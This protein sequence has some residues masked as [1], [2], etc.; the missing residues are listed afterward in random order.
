MG[1]YVLKQRTVTANGI[2]FHYLEMGEGPLAL[3]LH[4]FP[5]SAHAWRHLLPRLAAAGY[6]AVAPFMRGYAPTSVAASG[7]YHAMDLGADACALHQAL[8]GD[9]RAV[10]IGHDWGALTVYAAALI[11]P[12][13]WR[14]CVT[15]SVPPMQVYGGSGAMFAYPQIKR[16]FYFWFFQMKVAQSIVSAND[17]AFIDGLWADWSPGF[18]APEDLK[19]VK[20]CLAAPEN[21]EAAIGY[22]RSNIKPDEFGVVVDPIPPLTQPLL[23]L[24]GEQDGCIAIDERVLAAVPSAAGAGSEARFVKG[25]GHFM[26][27]AQP[28]LVN[29]QIIDFLQR[30]I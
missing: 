15:M 14:R 4:G 24:H 13:A 27:V 8:G 22:Y 26:L 25:A 6:R 3:C 18:D 12:G 28:D 29:G 19:N 21:L 11:T 5:D 30:A 1:E 16:S 20:A 2:H 23:Y 7:T 10:L 17:M 9:E